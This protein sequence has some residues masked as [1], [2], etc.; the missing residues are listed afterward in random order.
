MKPVITKYLVFNK[1]IFLKLKKQAILQ[2]QNSEVKPVF[3]SLNLGFATYFG[4]LSHPKSCYT[5][6]TE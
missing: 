5:D 3:V 6:G 4:L 2:Q 1:Y